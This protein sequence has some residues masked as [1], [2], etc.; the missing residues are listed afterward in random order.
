MFRFANPQN[1]YI[2][3]IVLVVWA[4]FIYGEYNRR[5]RLDRFGLSRVIEPLMPEVSKY[6]PRF[7][8]FLQQMVLIIL[9]F[10]LARPQSGAKVETVKKNSVEI[11]IALDVSNSMNATDVAP[12]R[13]EKAKMI[14]SKLIDELENDKVGLI[15]FA[16]DAYTQ[17]PI[18]ND[19]VSAK[20]ILSSINTNVVPS[21]GTSIGAAIE[22]ASNSFTQNEETDK[23]IILITDAENHET[24]AIQSA[25]S[26]AKQNKKVHVIGV[27]SKEG[28]VIPINKSTT[29]FLKDRQGNVVTTRLNEETGKEIAN[30]GNGIYVT[31]NNTNN[32]LKAIVSEIKKMQGSESE[33]KIY[34]E[35]DEQYRILAIIAFLIL[36]ADSFIL[37]GKSNFTKRINFFTD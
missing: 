8:F 24:D 13:L 11:E 4:I 5:K 7:K 17:I 14:L 34:S 26:A 33:Q 30:A 35:Y 36:F 20:M 1:L 21:Q 23:A 6:R 3:I 16:G 27:G 19:F 28:G 37:N 12:S 22:L 2:L 31:A 15:V 25:Q 18:T 29:N 9:I 32:A 10:V